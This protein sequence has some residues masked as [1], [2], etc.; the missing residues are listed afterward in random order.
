MVYQEILKSK[1]SFFWDWAELKDAFS[2]VPANE[3]HSSDTRDNIGFAENVKGALHL[4]LTQAEGR[5]CPRRAKPSF[6]RRLNTLQIQPLHLRPGPWC[7]A[8]KLQAR[9]NAR[10]FREA[11]D[12][13]PESQLLPSIMV[14]QVL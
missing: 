1:A 7:F 14:N 11:P 4:S 2:Y 9:L 8:K 3:S 5:L 13:D 6:H 12:L 10:I